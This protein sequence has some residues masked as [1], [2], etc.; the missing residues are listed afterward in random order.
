MNDCT[1]RLDFDPDWNSMKW[2]NF[3]LSIVLS[4]QE[5]P[6]ASS[7]F[8]RNAVPRYTQSRRCQKLQHSDFCWVLI[9]SCTLITLVL[10]VFQPLL[11]HTALHPTKFESSIA[12]PLTVH[13]KFQPCRRATRAKN[14]ENCWFFMGFHLLHRLLRTTFSTFGPPKSQP[15][16]L[17]SEIYIY[18]WQC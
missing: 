5:G 13:K 14:S 4:K 16:R 3:L 9:L 7:F 11:P 6:D 1:A 15:I 10:M 8:G 12:I 2:Q 18:S 17:V